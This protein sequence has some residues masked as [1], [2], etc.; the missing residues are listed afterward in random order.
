M[1]RS[2]DAHASS[3]DRMVSA[4]PGYHEHLRMSA[5]RMGLPNRGAGLHLLDLGCG[6]GAST[7]ALLDAAPDAQVTAVDASTQML[8]QA[9]TQDLAAARSGSCTPTPR[10]WRPLASPDRST[11]CSRR[12]WCAT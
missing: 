9:A 12:T 8:A 10:T 6:T 7:A 11:A 5:R 1:T 3:Y 2:F 4:N